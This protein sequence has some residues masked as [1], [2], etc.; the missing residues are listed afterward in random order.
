MT[1][2]PLRPL[3]RILDA[4]AR[5]ENPKAIEREYIRQRHEDMKDRSR[6]RAEGRLLVLGLFF[7]SIKMRPLLIQV[8]AFTLAHTITLALATLGIVSISG[9]IVEPLIALSIVYV[10]VENILTPNLTR[11]RPFVIFGFGL[12]H[13]LGFASVLSEFGLEPGHFIASLIAFNIGV[14]VGQ[15]AVILVAFLAVGLWFGK[16]DWYRSR[17]AIP[18]S[19]VIALVGAYWSFERVF[20]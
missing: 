15:L 17:I 9:N 16:R 10:A 11:W 5:G 3:A 13:G 20:L 8:S 1:R 12:L 14:E 7:F 19:V 18:A 6:A 2:T 4:R